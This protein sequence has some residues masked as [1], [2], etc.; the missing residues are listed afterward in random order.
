MTCLLALLLAAPPGQP[1]FVAHSAATQPVS[2]PLRSLSPDAGL[3]LGD[4]GP[5]PAGD[6][7]S[8][9][10]TD[11]PRPASPR[12]PQVILANGDR[13]RGTVTGGDRQSV[14]V[15]PGAADAEWKVPIAALAA[16][17]VNP[18]PAD[19]PADPAR[20]TWVEPGRRRDA[21]LLATGDVTR[22]TVDSFG[23]NP[24]AVRVKTTDVV[25][26]PL[27]RVAAIAFD[28]TLARLR[29][30]KGPYYRLV[31]ADG[32]RLSLTA[33]ASDGQTLT[34]TT[35]FNAPVAVPL[36]EVIALDVLQGKATY[37]S[38][39]KPADAKVEGYGGVTW[40]WAADR[41]VKGQPL[42]LSGRFGEE[43]FDKGLGTHPR[44]TLTYALDG[45]FRRFEAMVGL[46]PL[47][48]RRG[49][50]DVK[51]LVDG[52]DVTPPG[53][54]GLTAA[55]S[56][57]SVVVD[58]SKAKQLTLVVDFGPAGDVQDDVNWGDARLI[59]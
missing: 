9:R 38:D 55:G 57:K 10:R 54:A 28:P 26:L 2:G 34:G 6:L 19:T 50:A 17:W 7:V 46:D 48:G 39:L 33:A 5:I 25:T 14:T 12:G 49:I 1:A 36:D 23:A 3:K 43:T 45:R 13:V 44:T 51:V 29:K 16:V 30:P 58:V 27:D 47:T 52:T 21:V 11:R 40:P 59:E 15:R 42:R 18:P 37:L 35:L 24:A 53:L 4:S 22:G 41:T 8:I 56:P 20:Y 31:T 32:S